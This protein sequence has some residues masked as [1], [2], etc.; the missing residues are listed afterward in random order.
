MHGILAWAA[1]AVAVVA[2][3]MH[4]VVGGRTFVRPLLAAELPSSLRWTA[5]FAWHSGTILFALIAAGFVA[6]ATTTAWGAYA[7]LA[8]SAAVA[9]AVVGLLVCARA[10][11]SP[12]TFAPVLL[13]GAVAA[14]GVVSVLI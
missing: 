2:L 11:I 13:F 9:V 8:A 7:A 12:L 5:Y 10:R 3:V 1:A 6:G 4:L 14:V